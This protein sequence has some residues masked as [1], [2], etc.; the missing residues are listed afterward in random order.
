MATYSFGS[1]ARLHGTKRKKKNASSSLSR[2]AD[3]LIVFFTFH[4]EVEN[5]ACPTLRWIGVHCEDI[6]RYRIPPCLLVELS[7]NDEKKIASMSQ[8]EVILALK[9]RS[10]VLRTSFK[11]KLMLLSK[12]FFRFKLRQL[13]S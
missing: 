4:S 5:L 2:A 8:R 12:L 3:A 1:K 11:A 9:N 10:Q 6:E 7:K 13:W